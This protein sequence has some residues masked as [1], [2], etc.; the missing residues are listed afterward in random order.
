M[1]KKTPA[2]H[3]AQEVANW[4]LAW[5]EVRSADEDYTA[6]VLTKVSLNFLLWS[7]QGHHL[8]DHGTTLFSGDIIAGK[9][10][11]I[12]ANVYEETSDMDPLHLQ[13]DFDFGD[14][15]EDENKFLSILWNTYCSWC[16]TYIQWM[17]EESRVW[18]ELVS[19]GDGETTTVSTQRIQA[20][21]STLTVSAV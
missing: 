9:D 15:S 21:F 6:P 19:E 14:F 11:P 13:D 1:T 20:F 17:M 8:A 18:N 2:P 12:V 3:T 16:P 4:F 5:A 7:A 10:G